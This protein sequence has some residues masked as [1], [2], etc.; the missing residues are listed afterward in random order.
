MRG[1]A[2]VAP[3]HEKIV[4][5]IPQIPPN[6]Y[7]V[8]LSCARDE[9]HR[10]LI[11]VLAGRHEGGDAGASINWIEKIGQHPSIADLALSSVGKYRRILKEDRSKELVRAIGL[12]AHGCE[13]ASFVHLRRIFESLIE[14]AHEIESK[15]P[16]WNEDAYQQQRM[17]ERIQTLKNLLPPFLVAHPHLYS[18][19]SEGLHTLTEE[20]CAVA[21]PR[22]KLAIELILDQKIEQQERERKEREASQG[23]GK[24]VAGSE[25]NRA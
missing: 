24:Q 1:A 14:E 15:R 13:I 7:R 20:E 19:L 16:G 2:A 6:L 8:D 3:V 10:L 5:P 18:I 22:V 25:R 4:V 9:E 21:Y 12:H 23:L 11:L 17:G